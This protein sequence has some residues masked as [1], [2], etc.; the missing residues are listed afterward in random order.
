MKPQR[1]W[2]EHQVW[3][4]CEYYRRLGGP[5]VE[6]YN[7]WSASKSFGTED[8][9]LLRD[10]VQNELFARGVLSHLEEVA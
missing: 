8:R 6:A 5:W 1:D 9:R 7:R 10:R 3:Q 2:Y 4:F